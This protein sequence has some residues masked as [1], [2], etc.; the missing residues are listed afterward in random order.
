[1]SFT[2]T[3][4]PVLHVLPVHP[5]LQEHLFAPTHRPFPQPSGQY[6]AYSTYNLFKGTSKL[7]LYTLHFCGVKC[8]AVFTVLLHAVAESQAG[9]IKPCVSLRRVKLSQMVADPQKTRK[10]NP[11]KVKAYTVGCIVNAWT[12]A[13]CNSHCSQRLPLHPG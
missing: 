3:Y 11:T 8:F 12:T 1:M 5:L 13:P 4:K 2:H 6:P 10:F 9:E 7:I